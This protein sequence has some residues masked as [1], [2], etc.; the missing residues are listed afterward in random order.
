MSPNPQ[1]ARFCERLG[2]THILVPTNE[3]RSRRG[4]KAHARRLRLLAAG[5][6]GRTFVFTYH[7]SDVWGFY[8]L[9]LLS[10]ANRILFRQ[11][12][13]TYPRVSILQR[14]ARVI[15]RD[16]I[17]YQVILGV[18]LDV[19]RVAPNHCMFGMHPDRLYRRYGRF[20]VEKNPG[21]F[22]DN[23]ERIARAYGLT[24]R[25]LVYIVTNPVRPVADLTVHQ[26]L[27]R[28]QAAGLSVAVKQRPLGMYTSGDDFSEFE[29][30]DRSLPAEFVLAMSP[31][32]VLGLWSSA[33]NF[34][35]Q[36][37]RTVSLLNFF[38]PPTKEHEDYIRHFLDPRI[39]F[40]RTVQ[41]LEQVVLDAAT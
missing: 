22:R 15:L 39:L 17:I 35:C 1:V 29:I 24:Q 28:L 30:V 5:F 11:V 12:D 41:E 33:L 38:K 10:R 37:V 23:T 36:H 40:P 18:R 3:D 27:Q 4:L 34:T 25:D 20:T 6:A 19:F 21:A 32:V 8:L 26:L 31:R 7:Y 9:A 2:S 16:R 14:D 13:P